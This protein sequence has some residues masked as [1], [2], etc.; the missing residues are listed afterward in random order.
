MEIHFKHIIPVPLKESLKTGVSD[1][2]DKSDLVLKNNDRFLVKAPSGKGK[3]TFLHILYGIRNDYSGELLVDGVNFSNSTSSN[4]DDLRRNTISMVFQGL[5]LFDHLSAI[6]NIRLKSQLTNH[7]SEASI[8]EM[9]NL[10]GIEALKDQKAQTLSFG[11]KQRVAIIRALCQPFKWL[12]LDEPFSHL[13]E[14]NSRKALDLIM[15]EAEKQ[16]SGVILTSLGE[17]TSNHFTK[18]LEL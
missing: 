7:H 11:Q 6:E 9:M 14:E 13:D 15:R 12:L 8:L 18:S 10:L 3:S 1:I 17:L 16:S 5:Q 4:W 2:W